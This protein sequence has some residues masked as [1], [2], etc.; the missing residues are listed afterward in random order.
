MGRRSSIAKLPQDIREWV[1]QLIRNGR[2]IDDIVAHLKTMDADLPV[3]RSSVG[4]FKQNYEAS[5]ARYRDAQ[6]VAG[7]WVTVFRE[8]PE[9]DVGALIAEMLKTLAFQTMSTMGEDETPVDPQSLMF[10]GKAIRDVISATS[11]NED[12]IAKAVARALQRAAAAAELVAR[13]AGLSDA[14]VNEF[15]KKILGVT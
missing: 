13:Q 14:M 1:E 5:L 8:S 12:R 9:S 11:I 10:L 2:T 4:R 6:A 3:S 7:Q 15:R